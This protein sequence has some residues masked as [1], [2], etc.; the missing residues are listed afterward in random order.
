MFVIVIDKIT[1]NLF[2]FNMIRFLLLLAF[3]F[4]LIFEISLRIYFIPETFNIV[5]SVK[6]PSEKIFNIKSF[7][8]TYGSFL[9]MFAIFIL[10]WFVYRRKNYKKIE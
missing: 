9:I 4:L 6:I 10:S 2:Y 5:F 8:R 7:F 3:L 1:F